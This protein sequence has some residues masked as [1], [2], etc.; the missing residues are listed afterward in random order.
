VPTSLAWLRA[1]DQTGAY[2]DLGRPTRTEQ[3][4]RRSGREFSHW[5]D[6]RSTAGIVVV[7]IAVGFEV[8]FASRVSYAFLRTA[9]NWARSLWAS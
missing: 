8:R 2:D 3:P 1:R 7:H 6:G 9:A 4:L 5:T